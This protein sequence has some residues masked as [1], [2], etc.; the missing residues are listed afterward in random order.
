MHTLK[1]T[2]NQPTNQQL[3]RTANVQAEQLLKQWVAHTHTLDTSMQNTYVIDAETVGVL[4]HHCVD[5]Q[6]TCPDIERYF[7][8]QRSWE[9][10]L[11]CY[12]VHD[13]RE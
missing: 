9:G 12:L 10:W 11:A 13:A 4:A 6:F 5:T 3:Q 8:L 2:N 1:D 7:L